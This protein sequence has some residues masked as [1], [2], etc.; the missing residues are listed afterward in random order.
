MKCSSPVSANVPAHGGWL[1]FPVALFLACFLSSVIIPPFQ[2]PDEFDHVKRAYLLTQG[3]IVLDSP[4]GN[5]SGGMIDTGL[6]AYMRSYGNVPF[7]PDRKLSADEIDEAKSIQWAGAKE[8]SPAPGT[9]Y[10]FPLIYAPQATGLIIGEMLGVSVEQSYRLARFFVLVFASL[11]IAI[12]FL[13]H[14]PS[15]LVAALLVIPMSLFQFSSASLDGLSTAV[16]ILAISVF[17]RI[18]VE[19]KQARPWLLPVLTGSVILVVGCRV[20]LLPLILLIF[21]TFFFYQ[22]PQKP[23]CRWCCRDP[24]RSVAGRCIQ[25]HGRSQIRRRPACFK[26]TVLLSCESLLFCQGFNCN[27]HQCGSRK[28]LRAIL[29]RYFGLARCTI[30]G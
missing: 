27:T 29:L 26:N 2:S 11:I 14:P 1:L 23:D 30:P 4:E 21:G 6:L 8:F 13:I 15:P 16:S 22:E 12:A 24:C 3:R 18:A 17:M 28:I 7:H 5:S 20:H 19:K 25:K 9:G 10:Y